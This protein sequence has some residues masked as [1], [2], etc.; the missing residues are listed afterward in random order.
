VWS[1]C[2]RLCGCVWFRVFCVPVMC[3]TLVWVLEN[4]FVWV[5]M[6]VFVLYCV[7]SG[8]C[9]RLCV[10]GAAYGC[11]LVLCVGGY[12]VCVIFL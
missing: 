7:L 3:E 9:V 2:L 1:V 12:F 6:C 5:W 8:V 10:C 11:V 4:V